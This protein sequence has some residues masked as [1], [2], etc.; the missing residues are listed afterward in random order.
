[1]HQTTKVALTNE[2][3]HSFFFFSFFLCCLTQFV[4]SDNFFSLMIDEDEDDN[5]NA[6]MA[7]HFG[8]RLTCQGHTPRIMVLTKSGNYVHLLCWSTSSIFQKS[9]QAPSLSHPEV[10]ESRFYNLPIGST[11]H[12]PW[13][14]VGLSK[15]PAMP[16]LGFEP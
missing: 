11:A 9:E 15:N 16:L 13:V 3:L 4:E 8:V 5:S 7:L 1:M 14:E 12:P 10:D 2:L 6:A